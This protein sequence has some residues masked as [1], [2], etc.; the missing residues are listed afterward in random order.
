MR[1]LSAGPLVRPSSPLPEQ[2]LLRRTRS[3]SHSRLHKSDSGVRLSPLQPPLHWG[4]EQLVED[5]LAT[6]ESDEA[7]PVQALD[8]PLPSPKP[9]GIDEVEHVFGA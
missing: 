5:A 4:A 1:H 8:T 7:E 2:Q 3:L 9:G 6:E